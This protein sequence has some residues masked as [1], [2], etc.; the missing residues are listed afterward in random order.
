MV[1]AVD[2]G[3]CDAKLAS[4]NT[5][6]VSLSRWN[7]FA[8]RLLRIYV[9]KESPSQ[10]LKTLVQFVM[11]VYAPFWF[12][13]KSKPQ[14]IHGSRHLFQYIQWVRP[15]PDPV[16]RVV[17][18]YIQIN[19]FFCHPENILLSMLTD[20]DPK[21]RADAYEKV[22]EARQRPTLPIRKFVIPKIKFDCLSYTMMIDWDNL[23]S[24]YEPPCIQFVPQA[25]LVR[26]FDSG[27][28]LEIPGENF[29]QNTYSFR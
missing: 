15:F 8:S 4:Y 9:A 2:S 18:C 23:E 21:I 6:T 25:D 5:G 14:A 20:E 24:F 16:K 27:Q 17:H 12:L 29:A 10:E 28:I 22:L 7:T 3:V 13:V 26:L 11:K 1:H 19:R